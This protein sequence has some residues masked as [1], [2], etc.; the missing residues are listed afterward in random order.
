MKLDVHVTAKMF[1]KGIVYTAALIAGVNGYRN[2]V[3]VF[4]KT[5]PAIIEKVDVTRAVA[6]TLSSSD[7][8]YDEED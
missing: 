5:I 8:D 7:D 4:E 3:R 1:E 2:G 6:S